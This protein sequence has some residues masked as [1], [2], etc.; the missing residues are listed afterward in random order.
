MKEG[1]YEQLVTDLVKQRLECLSRDVFFIHKTKIDKEEAALILSK[2][3]SLAIKN[4]FLYLK[5]KNQIELQI[6]IANKIIHL[7]KEE[8]RYKDLDNDLIAAEG[9][10]L[11]AV[12]SKVDNHFANNEL[13][14]KEIMPYTRLTH[15]EL[16]TG[17][18]VGLS[19][20]SELKKEIRSSDEIDLL[21]SFIK[22]KGLIILL[23]DLE[24]FT[25]K[26]GRLRVIT[27]T[28]MGASDYRAIQL[29]ANLP[30]TEVKI[31]YN[32]GSE[33]LHAKAY[34]FK[35]NT[36]FHTAYIGSSNFSRSALTDGLEW[37]LKIT[38]R[39]VSHIIDKFQKTF[40]SYWQSD[41][42]ELYNDAEHS[43]RLINAL[44]P[45]TPLGLSVLHSAFLISGPSPSSLKYLKNWRLNVRSTADFAIS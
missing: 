1:V 31:S 42:F 28:Y 15:S 37:N 16:F 43:K 29:L 7:L 6:E 12:F 23:Q 26:G 13:H 36:G 17:G 20:E 5:D 44:Q 9:E 32:T 38:T 30:N 19:L 45:D 35:R 34:L 24:S 14:L 40:D 8:L 2:H 21:V 39:E 22:F 3:L 33:R 10:I 27:T 25:T 41:D 4:A 11:Q 18:N